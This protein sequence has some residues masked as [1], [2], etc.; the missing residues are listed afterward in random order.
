MSNEIMKAI[1]D[2]R[3]APKLQLIRKDMEVN[4]HERLL[5]IT[6]RHKFK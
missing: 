6:R 3:S 2:F 1:L 4:G 5:N